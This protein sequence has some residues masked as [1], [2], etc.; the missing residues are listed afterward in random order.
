MEN[1]LLNGY[2]GIVCYPLNEQ[3]TFGRNRL[4]KV[5][6]VVDHECYPLSYIASEANPLVI[7]AVRVRARRFFNDSKDDIEFNVSASLLKE[8]QEGS[9]GSDL[10]QSALGKPFTIVCEAFSNDGVPLRARFKDGFTPDGYRRD[11]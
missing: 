10:F 11:V 1:A 3:Y 7:G 9:M 8:L 5:K 4:Y 6:T 2:E